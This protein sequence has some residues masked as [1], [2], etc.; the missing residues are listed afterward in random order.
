MQ[1]SRPR[2]PRR[3]D[4]ASR[5]RIVVTGYVV[6]G[7]LGGMVWSN[8]QYLMGLAQL[9]HEVWFAEDSDDYPSC[10]DPARG[11]TGTDPT[12]GL[13]FANK[14]FPGVGV[15]DRWAYFDA[16]TSGWMGPAAERILASCAS[17][18]LLLDL[19]GVNP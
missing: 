4:A 14:V 11:V 12:Y 6:R 18:D 13:A 9:G 15:A 19:C 16:H 7:P 3:I 2:F 10:Y 1:M 5:L 17:A 8:L